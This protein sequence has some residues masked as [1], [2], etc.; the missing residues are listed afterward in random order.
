MKNVKYGFS[1]TLATADFDQ[2]IE[3]TTMSLKQE[4]FG[5]IADIDVRQTLKQKLGVDSGRYRILGACNPT[6]AHQSLT[7]EPELGLLL[8]CNVVVREEPEGRVAVSVVSPRRL[9]TLVDNAQLAPVAEDVERRLIHA[10]ERL[11]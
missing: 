1:K 10:L 11:E 9:F 6:L 2:A 7:A 4:G 3:R 5:V 8:P